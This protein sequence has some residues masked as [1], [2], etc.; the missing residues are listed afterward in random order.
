MNND[1]RCSGFP[2]PLPPWAAR[3][4]GT[5]SKLFFRIYIAG[6]SARNNECIASFR[7]ACATALPAGGYQIDV[8]DIVKY[9]A[10]AEANKI[11][12]TPTITRE[13]PVPQKRTIGDFME[14]SKAVLALN[15][16]IEDLTNEM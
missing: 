9:P 3:K 4:N 6:L 15:F 11:L 10:E 1:K 13:K 16:L 8:I 2:A 7:K 12:A 14:N 5:M